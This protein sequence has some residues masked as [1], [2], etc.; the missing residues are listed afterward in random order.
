[1][2]KLFAAG[3]MGKLKIQQGTKDLVSRKSSTARKV[4]RLKCPCEA[5]G[6]SPTTGQIK[7]VKGRALLGF[8]LRSLSLSHLYFFTSLLSRPQHVS[9]R[10]SC[11]KRRLFTSHTSDSRRP[12]KTFLKDQ[13]LEFSDQI[14]VFTGSRSL[15]FKTQEPKKKVM[16]NWAVFFIWPCPDKT[17]AV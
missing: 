8:Y 7:H 4:L 12:E 17:G 5:H 14:E 15:P 2:E 16:G 6:H 1:M 3:R 9:S 10:L 13:P 11:G